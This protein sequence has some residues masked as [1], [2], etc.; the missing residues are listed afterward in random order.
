MIFWFFFHF[1]LRSTSPSIRCSTVGSLMVN[2]LTTLSSSSLLVMNRL[3]WR[4]CGSLSTAFDTVC[5]QPSSPKNWHREYALYL[6]SNCDIKLLV[7][8]LCCK[9]QILIIGKSINF[10]RQSCHDHTQLGGSS[11]R[12]WFL[13]EDGMSVFFRK[14]SSVVGC[15]SKQFPFW[16]L[17][18]GE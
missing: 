5:Y 1:L 2:L 3:S 7:F 14:G 16:W 8:F 15:S 12:T 9:L 17:L 18:I 10:L 6:H 11:L 13:N 4:G